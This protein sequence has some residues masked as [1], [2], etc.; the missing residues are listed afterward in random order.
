MEMPKELQIS[1]DKYKIQRNKT[2]HAVG[3]LLMTAVMTP[4]LKCSLA[5]TAGRKLLGWIQ[6]TKLY[7]F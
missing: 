2:L 5:L 4:H 3:K 6:I 1:I 7:C